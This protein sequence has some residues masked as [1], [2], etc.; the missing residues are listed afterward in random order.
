MNLPK[1]TDN[2]WDKW[3]CGR[4]DTI[5][6][7]E[8][9][10]LKGTDVASSPGISAAGMDAELLRTQ[11][12]LSCLDL[13][14]EGS[15]KS[16][17]QLVS[18]QPDG[19]KLT[20]VQ[21]NCL[22]EA[23]KNILSA[24][25]R[26][27]AMRYMMLIHDIGKNKLVANAVNYGRSS[28]ITDHDEVIGKLLSDEFVQIRSQ[29][30]PNYDRFDAYCRSLVAGVLM[31]KGNLGHFMRAEAPACSVTSILMLKDPLRS[32]WLTHAI[33]DMAGALGHQDN[34]SSILLTSSL[35]EMISDC[36]EALYGE[37][38]DERE[39]YDKYLRSRLMR[40]SGS[41]C[42]I[43][44]ENR[45]IARLM[46]MMKINKSDEVALLLDAYDGLP[47]NTRS[48]LVRELNMSGFDDL[49]F[50]PY[51][52]PTLLEK[53]VARFDY[54]KALIC[55]ARIL[56]SARSTVSAMFESCA[57]GVVVLDLSGITNLLTEDFVNLG[58]KISYINCGDR[59]LKCV[60]FTA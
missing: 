4:L 49:A 7:S 3:K 6:L 27:N 54:M 13:I 57:T 19:D 52:A 60:G 34:G 44:E 18:S 46:C 11:C 20:Q 17:R 48:L 40:I 32:L 2:Q 8:A 22:H 58:K 47:G 45:S 15:E 56:E 23:F 43:N 26:M 10:L 39:V 41:A 1:L 28:T 33:L 30:L 31:I 35:F 9:L 29:I 24:A 37:D 14:F 42:D 12:A 25:D 50:L 16:Y 21:Y 59:T 55:F 51:Y 53:L 36:I 38:S 5:N